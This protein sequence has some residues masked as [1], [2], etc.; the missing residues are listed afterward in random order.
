MTTFFLKNFEVIIGRAA[1]EACRVTW[2]LGTNSAFALGPRFSVIFL[3]SRANAQL[4]HKFHVALHASHAALRMGTSNFF[5]LTQPVNL[6]PPN[7]KEII[8]LQ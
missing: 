1:C 2:N 5:A 6:P 3:G 4:V 7:A 8:K